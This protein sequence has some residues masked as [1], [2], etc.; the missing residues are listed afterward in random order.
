MNPF[1]HFGRTP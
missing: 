1:T